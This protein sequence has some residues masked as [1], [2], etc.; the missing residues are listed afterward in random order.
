VDAG[1]KLLLGVDSD[2]ASLKTFN[3]NFRGNR[4]V[5]LDLA[6]TQFVAEILR[7]LAGEIPDVLIA[8]PPCQG[9]SL[10][11][12]RRIDDERNRLYMSVI[13]LA[14]ELRPKAFVIE[15]VKGMKTLYGGLVVEEI[16][17][18]LERLGYLLAEPTILN[19]AGYGV[20]QFRERLFFVGVR[21]DLLAFD[22]PEPSHL[23]GNFVSCED[24][25]S[26]LPSLQLDL[27]Q[28]VAKHSSVALTEYQ[29]RMRR[30]SSDILYNHVGTRHT[31][32]VKSVIRLV[33]EGGNHKDLPPG[34]GTSR[35]FNE[36]WTRYHSKLPS[37]TIDTGHRNHFHYKYD[38]VPTIRENARLQSFPD[39]FVFVG[40]KT[41]QNKQVG[42]AVPPL[43]AEAIA[44][45]LLRSLQP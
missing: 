44:R 33:P 27:G 24:A 11:G 19:S 4:G 12:P 21:S 30:F 42:N 34:V 32:L 36:A 22:F 14:R 39:D 37:R 28:E 29:L 40:T 35:R 38:R 5:K 31:D 41:Q 16:K 23:P 6:S 25:L 10:T 26:D 3:T 15:N 45:R 9:F 17:K 20:P 8:G 2:E 7:K 18:R 43:L 13:R 1:Y